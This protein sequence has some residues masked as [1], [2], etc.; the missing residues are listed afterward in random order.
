MKTETRT[1]TR[2]CGNRRGQTT[3]RSFPI[4][5]RCRRGRVATVQIHRGDLSG[6]V[7]TTKVQFAL[8]P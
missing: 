2:A 7:L 4:Y 5:R 3:F 8:L 6:K 1:K